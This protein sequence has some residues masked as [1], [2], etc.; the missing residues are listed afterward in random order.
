MCEKRASSN[1]LKPWP[2]IFAEL[3]IET[4]IHKAHKRI[5]SH[6]DLYYWR[7]NLVQKQ[8]ILTLPSRTTLISRFIGN[9]EL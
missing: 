2:K 4:H 3:H 5:F 1:Q 8:N 9:D 6:R 7:V